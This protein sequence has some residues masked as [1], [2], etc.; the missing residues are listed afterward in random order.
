MISNGYMKRIRR[1]SW[2]DILTAFTDAV[3]ESI[4]YQALCEGG[5]STARKPIVRKDT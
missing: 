2:G 3:R 1:R 4:E 5:N